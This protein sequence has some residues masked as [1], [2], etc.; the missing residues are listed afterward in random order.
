VAVDFGHQFVD[1]RRALLQ[2]SFD[3]PTE[4]VGSVSRVFSTSDNRQYDNQLRM[5][6]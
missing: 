4:R 1:S 5:R 2:N 3:C 6:C